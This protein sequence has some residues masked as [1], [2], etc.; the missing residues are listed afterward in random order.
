MV[1]FGVV[2]NCVEH[3]SRTINMLTV[4]LKQLLYYMKS[5]YAIT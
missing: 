2:Y 4:N 3:T 5:G 1:C